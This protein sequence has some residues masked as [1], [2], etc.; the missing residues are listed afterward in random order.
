MLTAQIQLNPT[1]SV[2]N[3]AFIIIITRIIDDFNKQYQ[4]SFQD[5][6]MAKSE[7]TNFLSKQYRDLLF[8]QSQAES[9]LQILQDI[10]N[11]QN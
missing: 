3:I 11:D 7:D 10:Q 8:Q 5:Y 6:F 4:M 1:L 2:Y 9:L